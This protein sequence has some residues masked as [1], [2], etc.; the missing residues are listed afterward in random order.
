VLFAATL[1]SLAVL[2]AASKQIEKPPAPVDPVRYQEMMEA[3]V[4]DI[5]D[6][7][8][9]LLEDFD[10]YRVITPPFGDGFILRQPSSPFLLPFASW[11]ALP[12]EFARLPYEYENSIKVYPITVRVDGAAR[13][14]VFQSTLTGKRL[15]ALP[16]GYDPDARFRNASV[17][18]CSSVQILAKLIPVESVEPY[19]YV[20]DRLSAQAVSL[21]SLD[22][23]MQLMRSEEAATNIVFEAFSRQTNGLKMI[24]GYPDSFTNRLDIFTCNDLMEEVWSIAIRELSTEG[25]NEIAWVDSSSGVGLPV[26][27]YCAANADLDTDQDSYPDMRESRV[28]L[29]NPN[30]PNSRPVRISGSISYSGI[31]TGTIFM[32]TLT[33]ADSWSLAKSIS[34]ASPGA[35][36][37]AEIGNDEEYYF[38]TFRDVNN[39]FIREVWEPWGRYSTNALSV[40][41]DV[42]GIDM[43]LEDQPSLWGTLLYTG[44]ATGNV[45]VLAVTSSNSWQSPYQSVTS[46]EQGEA[47]QTGGTMFLSFP[48]NFSITELPSSNYWIRAFIDENYDGV[49]NL[50]VEAAGQ[51]AAQAIALSNRVTGLNF[52]LAQDTDSDGMPDWWEWEHNFDPTNAA[53]GLLDRDSDEAANWKEYLFNIDPNNPDSDG[54]GIP[55]GWEIRY[56]LTP[57]TN[58]A[59]GDIDSDGLIN[60]D[61]YKHGADPTN[62]DCDNDQISDGPNSVGSVFAGPDPNPWTPA[63]GDLSMRYIAGG[64]NL[65]IAREDSRG[66]PVVA[67]KGTDD[68]GKAQIYVMQWFGVPTDM[69]LDNWTT[70]S[71]H[72]EQFAASSSGSG[73]STA[74]NGI[75]DFDMALDANGYPVVT[76]TEYRTSGGLYLLRWSG[77]NWTAQ[78]NSYASSIAPVACYSYTTIQKKNWYHTNGTGATNNY[79]VTNFFDRC[80]VAVDTQ[81]QPVVTSIRW[82]S[83]NASIQVRRF[84]GSSWVGLGSSATDSGITGLGAYYSPGIAI[85]PDGR[86]VVSYWSSFRFYVRKWDGTSSWPTL[87]SGLDSDDN[88]GG[89]CNLFSLKVS[90]S[91]NTPYLAWLHLNAMALTNYITYP[92]RHGLWLKYYNGSTWL[93]V[94]KSSGG[95]GLHKDISSYISSRSLSL[96][97]RGTG[98]LFLAWAQLTGA[99][100]QYL[101]AR[102]AN[103]TNWTDLGNSYT[104]TGINYDGYDVGSVAGITALGSPV[105]LYSTLMSGNS[106]Q[107]NARQFM[108]D[109]DNDGLSDLYEQSLGLD[110]AVADSDLDGL[111]DWEE[112]VLYGTEPL[113]ADSD[114]DGLTDGEEVF[115]TRGFSSDPLST[116][117][118]ADGI[119]DNCDW[120]A[121][122]PVGDNDADGLADEL[123]P[124]DDNDGWSDDYEI[125]TSLTDP[126]SPDTDCDGIPDPAESASDTTPPEITVIEPEEGVSL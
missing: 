61:E 46:W 74:S 43:T 40:T 16:L 91:N 9:L 87:G 70:L 41:S 13:E 113:D 97:C 103:G 5:G 57:S 126:L 39:N 17:A 108:A 42:S 21:Q 7:Q 72:W 84:N 69:S 10:F 59:S 121:N 52:T 15:Y 93:D 95:I 28:F 65:I 109:S 48:M 45:Y 86:P 1:S 54:D 24:I 51:Y 64:G 11:S 122:S 44:S 23:G 73:V 94:G 34:L 33:E 111:T 101:Y 107:M 30:D 22:G 83:P 78:G 31:E 36:T 20:A 96:S 110:P 29:T 106:F 38:K 68:S 27:L 66:R 62:P 55:D 8:Q 125:N 25:T 6:L 3:E 112:L 120:F 53:D 90:P 77:T 116:D 123:D 49:F 81:N 56:G 115:G 92:P 58:D 100:S 88:N 60:L 114:H 118:D 26:R 80:A 117:S 67:W 82:I 99:Y 89:A 102:R 105:A 18:P 50:G 63:P 47:S 98:E 75:F 32:L 14:A 104:G 35:Y 119:Q 2:A 12:A 85:G 124:D 76:W 79:T 37:N 71:G 19:L 4:S